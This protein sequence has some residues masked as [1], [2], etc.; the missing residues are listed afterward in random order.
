MK[1]WLAVSEQAVPWTELAREA[2]R[3]VAYGYRSP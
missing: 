2:H 3:F 1:E